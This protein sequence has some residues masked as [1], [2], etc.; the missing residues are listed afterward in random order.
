MHAAVAEVTNKFKT[1]VTAVFF[2]EPARMDK[3]MRMYQRPGARLQGAQTLM[4]G[5]E[6]QPSKR[7]L[8]LQMGCVTSLACLHILCM[9]WW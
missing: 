2:P 1:Q 8:C 7:K 3:H 5:A 6:R 4:L 9:S